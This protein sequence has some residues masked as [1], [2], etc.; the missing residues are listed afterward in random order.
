MLVLFIVRRA[1]APLIQIKCERKSVRHGFGE[2][3]GVSVDTGEAKDDDGS[4][5]PPFSWLPEPFGAIV[6]PR[7]DPRRLPV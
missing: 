6:A 3:S 4:Q 5:L 2:Y 1:G 7:R